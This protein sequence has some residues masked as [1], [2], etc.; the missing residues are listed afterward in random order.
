[1]TNAWLEHVKATQEKNKG[2]SYKEA[3]VKAKETYKSSSSGG[4]KKAPPTPPPTPAKKSVGRPRKQ[5]GTGAFVG[6]AQ[7]AAQAIGVAGDVSKGVI[8]AVQNDKSH[9][10]R[11]D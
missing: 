10:G 1:M 6:E 7:A 8:S 5:A 2:I 11:Y 9:N 4:S 3:M